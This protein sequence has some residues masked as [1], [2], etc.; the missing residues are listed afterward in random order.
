M[1]AYSTERV[2]AQ[3]FWL[4]FAENFENYTW[5]ENY[6]AHLEAVTIDDVRDVAQRYLRPQKRTVGYFIPTGTDGHAGEE[7]EE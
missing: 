6:I 4:A 2:T 3:A 7:D 5:F 1:F